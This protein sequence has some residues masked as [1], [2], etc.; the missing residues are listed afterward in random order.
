MLS[1]YVR[2][3]AAASSI[4]SMALSGKNRSEIYLSERVA[5]AIIALSCMRTPW[6]T[7]YLSLSPLNIET[8]SSTDGG[9]II[10]G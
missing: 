7:S 2:S 10:T 6:K 1:I 5:A 8:V 3:R 4:R 9:L